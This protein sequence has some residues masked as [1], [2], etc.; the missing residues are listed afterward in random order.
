MHTK[1][2][3]KLADFLETKVPR[4]RFNM[5]DWSSVADFSAAQCDTAAC[6]FGWATTIPSFR[7]AGLSSRNSVFGPSIVPSFNGLEGSDA[8]EEFFGLGSLAVDN[9]FYGHSYEKPPT[10]KQVAKRIRKLVKDAG[11]SGPTGSPKGVAP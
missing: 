7:R 1:R 2:L 6:A 10:P 3:L 5:T 4:K 9:L 11:P 8:A